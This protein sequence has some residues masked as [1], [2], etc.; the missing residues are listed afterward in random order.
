MDIRSKLLSC[1]VPLKHQLL[2]DFYALFVRCADVQETVLKKKILLLL[3][4]LPKVKSNKFLVSLVFMDCLEIRYRLASFFQNSPLFGSRSPLPFSV[5]CVVSGQSCPCERGDVFLRPFAPLST[6]VCVLR[7][8]SPPSAAVPSAA[9]ARLLPRP[10][11]PHCPAL[12]SC[13]LP[14][15]SLLH[16]DGPFR[17]HW[18]PL[19]RQAPGLSEFPIWLREHF[20]SKQG[21]AH[22]SP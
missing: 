22:Y 12:A 20:P 1:S 18:G 4:V 7:P 13:P 6:L 8:L 16:S 17:D 3:A 19:P 5:V 11:C 21:S 9:G 15:S 10:P 14:S 2:L